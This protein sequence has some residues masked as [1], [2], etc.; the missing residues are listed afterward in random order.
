MRL[1]SLKIAEDRASAEIMGNYGVPDLPRRPE[2]PRSSATAGRGGTRQRQ[3]ATAL[4]RAAEAAPG[5]VV[6]QRRL[7]LRAGTVRDHGNHA[8]LGA[9]RGQLGKVGVD[10]APDPAKR[11]AEH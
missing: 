3:A 4:A 5:E 1:S 10:L 2:L 8:V 6:A 7:P 11:D 9:D